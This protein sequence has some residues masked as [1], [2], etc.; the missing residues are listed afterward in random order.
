MNAEEVNFLL[1]RWDQSEPAIQ[2]GIVAEF[3]ERAV[4]WENLH[5]ART[6]QVKA[7]T[8]QRNTLLA[9][10]AW[11]DTSGG[12]RQADGVEAHQATAAAKS[13]KANAFT[14]SNRPAGSRWG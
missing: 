6:E 9:I 1:E 10:L 12:T 13:R 3:V 5:D 2:R 4:K 14:K 8:L 7:C 11:C